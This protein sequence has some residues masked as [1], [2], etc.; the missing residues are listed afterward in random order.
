MSVRPPPHM[1]RVSLCM[2]VKNE[3]HNL[4]ACIE[5][6]AEMVHEIVIVDTGSSDCT[7]EVAARY[8][9]KVHTFPWVDSFAAARTESLRHATSDWIFWLDADDRIDAENRPRLQQLLANLGDENFAYVMKCLCLPKKGQSSVAF[10]HIRLF[11]NHPGLQWRYRIHEQI[12][13]A[14]QQFGAEVRPTDVRIIHTGYQD[15]A[16]ELRKHERNLRLLLLEDAENP[17]DSFTLFNLGWAYHESNR[18]AE[19]ESYYRRSLQH[20]RS[21]PLFLRKLYAML[22]RVLRQRGRAADALACCREGLVRYPGDAELLLQMSWALYLHRD[23]AGAE[24]CLLQLLQSSPVPEGLFEFSVDP[25]LR[26]HVTRNN[27]AVLYRDQGRLAE[28]ESQWRAVLAEKHDSHDAWLGLGELYLSQERWPEMEEILARMDADPQ[29]VVQAAILRSQQHQAR[30]EFDAARRF[31]ADAIARW[32]KALGLRLVLSRVLW[33]EGRDWAA[34]EQAL[35]DVLA[36]DPNNAEARSRL[37]SRAAPQTMPPERRCADEPPAPPSFPARDGQFRTI[38]VEEFRQHFGAPDTSQAL[39]AYTPPIDTHVVLALLARA[40]PQR[41]LEIGTATGHMTANL[42]Q[43]SLPSAMV[44]SLGTVADLVSTPGPQGHENPPR[45]DFGRYANYFGKADKVLFITADSLHYDFHRLSPLDFAFIDGAH[46]LAHVLSD[47]LKVY[48]ELSPRGC[49]VWHDV[50]SPVAWVEVRQ[51]LEK[52]GFPETIYHVAGTQVAFLHKQ[53]RARD[54]LERRTAAQNS[55]AT[56]VAP[57]IVV[58]PQPASPRVVWEGAIS[59]EHSLALVNRQLCLGLLERGHEVSLRPVRS[60]PTLNIPTCPCPAQLTERFDRCLSGPADVYVRHAWPPDF[61]PP[62]DGHW[63]M[64]QPWEFGSLPRSWV[65]PMTNLVD[66]VWVYTHYLRDCYLQSGVPADRVQVVP[67]GVDPERYS[68]QAPPLPLQ[69]TKRF[70]FLFVGGTIYRKGIDLLLDAYAAVFTADEDVCLVIKDV[71]ARSFYQ[72]QTAH[73][74]IARLREQP[75]APAVEYLDRSLTEEELA[76][77]YTACDCLVQPYRGEGFGLPIAEAMACGRPVIVTD[78]GAALDFCND[79]NSYLVR[80]EVRRFT[81][82]QAFGLETVDHPWLAEVDPEALR[83]ALRRV[84][85][86]PEEATAKGAA[87]AVHIRTQFT[88]GQA[89]AVAE[90]RLREL[91]KQPVRRATL[92]VAL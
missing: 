18:L 88:W 56:P 82:K 12:L 75:G 57:D 91:V 43:W 86:H 27:L 2:I 85:E 21:N 90:A 30:Q 50:V 20:A 31:L 47:S 22:A 6:V 59:E 76:G 37:L 24:S 65:E 5:P 4:P 8:G 13:P 89:A 23:L 60:S 17:G 61:T 74:R 66:E 64:V 87:A 25:G 72:G 44:F 73:E 42:T 41:I 83:I 81:E 51:A 55:P 80:A 9:A 10:D 78:Y 52:T 32:P 11:R 39:H 54:C 36:L 77:L 92:P 1:Q 45:A 70:K 79:A 28:A 63:V 15:P 48:Q 46:D 3:E 19:A 7:R 34:A 84:V 62:P 29:M 40:R 33:Q 68:P 58:S 38:T 16:L 14:L 49:L 69:T 67:L 71:G 35:R 26:G 53:D